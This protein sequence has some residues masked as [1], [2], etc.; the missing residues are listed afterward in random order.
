MLPIGAQTLAEPAGTLSQHIH[1]AALI[2]RASVVPERDSPLNGHDWTQLATLQAG[3]TGVQTGSAQGGGNSQRGFGAAL[4]ISGARPDQN[5][6]R[7]DGVSI[8]DY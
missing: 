6:Y 4:S 1:H 3:V 2:Y 7:L 8:N 5:N